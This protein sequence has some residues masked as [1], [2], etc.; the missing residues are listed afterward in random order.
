MGVVSQFLIDP[1]DTHWKVVK[2]IFKYLKGTSMSRL[3]YD[4]KGVQILWDL[5]MLIGQ[6]ILIVEDQHQVIVSL[7]WE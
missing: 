4:G 1:N 6:G 7:L 2:R 5:Q 3:L